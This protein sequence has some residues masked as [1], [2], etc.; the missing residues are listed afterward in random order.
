L[1]VFSAAGFLSGKK[2]A[3]SDQLWLVFRCQIAAARLSASLSADTKAK[4]L[5]NTIYGWF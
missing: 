1:A 4:S 3:D 5:I 2:H